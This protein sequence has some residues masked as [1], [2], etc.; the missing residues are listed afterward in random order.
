MTSGGASR[1]PVELRI[2]NFRPE[3]SGSIY[4]TNPQYFTTREREREKFTE[5]ERSGYIMTQNACALMPAE[6]ATY[7]RWK[8]TRNISIC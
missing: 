7:N 5:R 2:Y 8:A 1:H 3:E 4:S 6:L